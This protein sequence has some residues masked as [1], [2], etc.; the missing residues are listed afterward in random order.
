[1]TMYLGYVAGGKCRDTHAEPEQRTDRKGRIRYH[2]PQIAKQFW[3]REE[4]RRIGIYSW[5]GDEISFKRKGK[6][7]ETEAVHS[8]FLPNY[9]FIEMTAAQFFEA[10]AVDHVASTLQVLSRD[11]VRQLERFKLFV[12]AEFSAAQRVDANKRASV[13]EYVKGQRLRVLSGPFTEMFA[14]F[15]K[16]VRAGHD[17]WPRVVAE[18]EGHKVSFDPLDIRAG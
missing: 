15:D 16:M 3:V 12:E 2:Y 7:R 9:I 6:S 13:A 1:M 8:P 10:I 11:D 14:S 18:I 5:C 4:L 17:D